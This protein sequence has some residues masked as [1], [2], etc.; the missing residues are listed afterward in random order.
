MSDNAIARMVSGYLAGGHELPYP[1]SVIGMNR[2]IDVGADTIIRTLSSSD[3]YV[4]IAGISQGAL[5]ISVAKSK[6]MALPE[7]QRPD[8]DRVVFVA[9]SDPSARDGLGGR[10]PGLYIP[11]VDVTFRA[12]PDTPYDTI[13][14]TREYDGFADFPDRP[15]NLV[16]VANA[17]MGIVYVHPFYGHEVDLEQ[18][19]AHQITQTTNDLGGTDTTYLAPT[20]DLPLV[21]PLRDLKVDERIVEAIEA[22]LRDIVNAG[23]SRNDKPE[24]EVSRDRD[25]IERPDVVGDRDNRN[26]ERRGDHPSRRETAEPRRHSPATDSHD[27][28]SDRPEAG[29][30]KSEPTD[31]DE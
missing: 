16:A 3:G 13:Y 22:P 17:L 5:A 15:L 10:F 23:Y 8:A 25:G 31:A 9:I 19:P 6:L 20:D 7:E 21:Q 26:Q 18:I 29:S 2:S 1:H 28:R 27:E 4:R 30:E 12:P 11:V 14:I 24:P